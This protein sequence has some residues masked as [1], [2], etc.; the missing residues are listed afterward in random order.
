MVKYIFTSIII[1]LSV[2]VS[3]ASV[4]RDNSTVWRLGEADNS[5]KEFALSPDGFKDFLKNDF[6]WEDKNF[7]VGTSE[8]STDW[9]YT[10]PGPS[11]D[12][13]GTSGTAGWR[14]HVL[15]VLF[16]I[17]N[18]PVD[19]SFKLIVDVF[20]FNADKPPLVKISMN[21]KS[22]NYQLPALKKSSALPDA[23][24]KGNEFIIEIPLSKGII[25]QGV[26]LPVKKPFRLNSTPCMP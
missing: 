3:Y 17:K 20:D 14:S 13:G 7:I 4:K 6:G 16:D 2:Q 9:P 11:D 1:A 10:L 26:F 8:I 5:T 21:G 24:A 22:W 19:N 12:W 23:D 18:E 15:N 25:R